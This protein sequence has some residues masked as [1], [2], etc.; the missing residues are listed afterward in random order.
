M[1]KPFVIESAD[2]RGGYMDDVDNVAVDQLSSPSKNCRITLGGEVYSRFGTEETEIDLAEANKVFTSYHMPQYN[3]TF[4]SGN[5][6]V[7]YIDHSRDDEVIDTGLSLTATETTRFGEYAGDIFTINKTDGLRHIHVMR[8][9]DAAPNSGDT[10]I[11]VD[12]NGAARLSAFS[13]TSG[14]LRIRG[15]NEAYNAVNTNGTITLTGTLSTT[16]TD[17]DI[18][19]VVKDISSGRPKGTMLTFWKERMI[20][21]GSINDTNTDNTSQIVYM[22]QFASARDLQKII[23][24]GITGGASEEWVGKAGILRNVVTTRDYVYYFKEDETYFSSVS[25]V[26]P[27]TGATSPQLLS[28]NYGCINEDCAVDI[29]SGRIVFLTKNKRI[30]SI[31]ISTDSGAAQ[32]FPNEAFDQS[33][34][35]TLELIDG[36]QPYARMVY[37]KGRRIL[38]CQVSVQGELITLV[39][40]N[41]IKKWLPPDYGRQF[42]S[43]FER[44]GI[45][46]GT[47]LYDDTIYEL[48][49]GLTD[50]EQS[51]EC[52]MAHG[53]MRYK[54]S[55]TTCEWQDVELSGSLGQNA[56]LSVETIVNN[57]T[58]TLKQV[59]SS[60]L[61][62]ANARSLTDI[63]IGDLLIGGI[64]SS[65]ILADWDRKFRIAP[66]AYGNIYQTIL[67]STSPFTLKS[68]KI[69]AKAL[70]NSLLTTS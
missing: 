64:N 57:G 27:T 11:V 30:I 55:R 42:N 51:I 45:L 14:N 23:V 38:Y 20:I 7:K 34:R 31:D 67:S 12:Q 17:N 5:G 58:S 68:Y 44:D 65:I 35:R 70:T 49:K 56:M 6:K 16:Y 29:G 19:I 41:N 66:T 62:Y 3:I 10:T 1:E 40:D 48:D 37:H 47:D 54:N 24:F 21:I 9:N 28:N 26:D 25:S 33:V 13:N 18:A 15:T 59:L 63:A 39:Y 32:V 2:F 61:S 4:V 50:G 46:F 36:Q 69:A 43:F 53:L 22:S 60:T 52:V 8:L